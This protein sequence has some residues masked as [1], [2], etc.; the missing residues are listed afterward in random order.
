[1]SEVY[2]F[3]LL[4]KQCCGLCSTIYLYAA[5]YTSMQHN[6][7]LRREAL[8]V[9][10]YNHKQGTR[11]RGNAWD[12]IV[13]EL[14]GITDIHFNVTK[15]CVR[16]RYNLLLDNFKKNQKENEKASG[17]EVEETEL[18]QLL[19]D[20]LEKTN[21]AKRNQEEES[22]NKKKAVEAERKSAEEQRKR[23]LETMTETRKRDEENEEPGTSKK[24]YRRTGSDTLTYSREKSQQEYELRDRE[25]RMKEEEGEMFRE[26]LL[27]RQ[28]NQN[29][30]MMK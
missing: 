16:D 6:I 19:F 17:I 7:L 10:P 24:Q 2:I 22:G 4:V 11:E 27:Q 5:R 20:L 26:L 29:D 25:L 8:L 28:Q 13:Q 14:N 1:M 9:E 15:R 30:E 21:E 23:A 12:L 18:D 3:T